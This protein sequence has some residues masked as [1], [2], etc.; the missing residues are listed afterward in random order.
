VAAIATFSGYA[1]ASGEPGV[2][3]V[4]E[5]TMAV[6]V[7]FLVGLWVLG[8]LARPLSRWKVALMAGVSAAFVVILATPGI[9]E[10]FD[11]R[12][13]S[14]VV[15]LAGIGVAAIAIA[16]LE[17]GWQLLDWWRHRQGDLADG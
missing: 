5:R 17:L 12:L 15:F 11:L 8:I 10:F 9:R 6:T 14:T 4:E 2:R 1:L 16:V 13:P 7:L 3:L